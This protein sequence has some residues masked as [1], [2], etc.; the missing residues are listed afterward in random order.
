MLSKKL[1]LI[2]QN[3][4]P[5]H[6]QIASNTGWLLI[7]RI[8]RMGVGLFIGV[9]IA[10]Y[11]GPE[12]FG[13]YNYA[14]AFASLFIA[15]ATLGLDR[16]VVRNI[17]RDP[18]CK[19]EILGTTFILKFGG[20]VLA[21]FL[22]IGA[23]S[24][25]RPDDSLSLWLVGI[26]AAGMIFQAFDTIDLWFQSQVQSKYAV[27]AKTTAFLLI[28]LVR[29]ALLQTQALLIAFAWA[30]LA[31]FASAAVGLA[32]TYRMNG[33]LIQTWK[34]SLSCAKNL[35]NDSW[36]L[37]LSGFA[38]YVQARIDQIML[39]QMI[40]DS[41]VGRYSAAMKLI[42]TFG[43]I[44]MIIQSSI[45]PTVTKA[46][47]QNE[48]AYYTTL[49]NIYRLMFILFLITAIPVLLF[50]KQVVIILLGSQYE[51]SAILLSLL[52]IRL[53]FANFGVAKSLF[54]ANE[55][56]FKYSLITAITG[57]S[58]NILINYFLIPDYASIGAIWSSIISFTVTVFLIDLFYYRVRKNL[59][60]MLLAI[61]TPWKFKLQ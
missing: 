35:L 3:L 10:R 55:N 26:T 59:W 30:G 37:I 51:G 5:K 41:E 24:V 20:G 2:S 19:N 28:T 46:K 13:R 38:I 29:V 58:I 15:F 33:H 14:I 48:T 34:V 16:I 60:V 36:P 8:V 1:K 21:L 49:L 12:Q 23:I 45:A 18:S 7:D 39:G 17:V 32:I 9:W 40:G 6:K 27:Y 22:S 43:F 56:L 53:F 25:I 44:P 31:E 50:S 47:A 61:I 57:T 42:E 54:I 4:S 11:L 52:S